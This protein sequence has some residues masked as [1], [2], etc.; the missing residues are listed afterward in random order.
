MQIV[1]DDYFV[2]NGERVKAA[3]E[4]GACNAVLLKANQ[5]G[6]I[7]QLR[8]AFAEA[9]KAG[10]GSIV[11]ARSGETEDNIIVHLALGLNA[12]Q[13]KVGSM[14]RSERT[15]KWNEAIR[16]EEAN[17]LTFFGIAALDHK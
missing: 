11:S 10:Y 9:Q 3:A 17:A 1:G 7:T 6:T 8:H 12:G 14:T 5:A 16:L 2:T 13:L 15:S 4:I